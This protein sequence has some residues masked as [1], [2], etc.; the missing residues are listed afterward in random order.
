M[1]GHD[2]LLAA[3][4][5]A[6]FFANNI[7]DSILTLPTL[8]ALSRLFSAPIT[9]ICP[10]VA[11]DLCFHEV[12][13]NFVDIERVVP[14]GHLTPLPVAADAFDA[15][16][17]QIGVVDVFVN[18]VP[19]NMPSQ[20]VA[21]R[22]RERLGP[23]TSIGFTSDYDEYDI[24]VSRDAGHSADLLFTL[25]RLFDP[26]ARTDDYAQ[27]LPIPPHVA[28][29]ARSIRSDLPPRC[30]VLVVHADTEW[31]AKQW[32]VTRLIDVLDRFLSRHRDYVAWVVGM[33]HE[34]LNVGSE[35]VRV[36]PRLGLPLD[37]A[38]ALVAEANLFLGIDSSM[39]HAADLA[40]V[41]GVGLFGP[42]RSTT[43]GFRFGPHRHVDRA[44][45]ADIDV[46]DVLDA[47]EQL[48]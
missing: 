27:P 39:L 37:L 48:A 21:R 25:A 17:A 13:P 14:H 2:E 12:S 20:L 45:M 35:R 3:R 1:G 28:A 18:A 32:P 46:Q 24:A 11:F 33:G 7:G 16:A 36:V 44:T 29:Q 5:P 6:V 31:T 47:L 38:A 9:L 40:R 23:A 43:W 42:T 34:D 22:L 4:R 41:P 8:R 10:K 15:L 30:K 26:S 19:Y